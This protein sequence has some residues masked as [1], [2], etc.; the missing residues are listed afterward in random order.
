M[1]VH[2]GALH[3]EV[4]FLW[5]PWSIFELGDGGRSEFRERRRCVY[6]VVWGRDTYEP[7]ACLMEPMGPKTEV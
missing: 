3:T 6:V 1:T 4:C 2:L 7:H 5:Y